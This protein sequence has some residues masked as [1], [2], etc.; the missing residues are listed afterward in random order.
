MKATSSR[1]AVSILASFA[2]AL[3]PLAVRAEVLS[4]PGQ[5]PPVIITEVQT[6]LGSG[7]ASKEF[8][9]LYNT[10]QEDI[11]LIGWQLWY[12]SATENAKLDTPGKVISLGTP[13]VPVIIPANGYLVIAH[14]SYA[15]AITADITYNFAMADNGTL[16]LLSLFDAAACQLYSEDMVGWGSAKFYEGAAVVLPSGKQVVA[17]YPAEGGGYVDT[18]VNADDFVALAASA[19]ATEATPGEPNILPAKQSAGVAEPPEH[20][21]IVIDP[22]CQ[23]I[24][25]TEPEEEP[26]TPVDPAEP[27]YIEE[28]PE[29][30]EPEPSTP[31][32]T[33]PVGNA[34]LRPPSLSEILPN[35]A[36]PQTDKDDEFIEVYN[37]NEVYFDLSGYIL[38][39]GLTTKRRY[40]IPAGTKLPPKAF[41]AFF[42]AE[43]KLALSNS[44]SQVALLDP[45]GRVLVISEPYGAAK[46]GQAWVFANGIWQWTTK[47]TPNALNVVSAPAVKSKSTAKK[48]S[49]VSTASA[50]KS[51]T[52]SQSGDVRSMEDIEEATVVAASSTPLHPGALALIA[53][54]AVLYGAY[55]YRRDVA[56]RIHQFRANRAAR[57]ALR[58]SVKGG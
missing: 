12:I 27:P 10:T 40:T 17:R 6:G 8:I 49:S 56:N 44:G 3:A 5:L 14:E 37:P 33:I 36:S 25:P 2:V 41:L 35:P 18:D 13:E 20:A 39:V 30:S 53:A 48:S 29:V 34:G 28:P 45:L 38:E 55:E 23:L 43:T 26:S 24:E 47:P 21:G 15:T 4:E 9:E 57:R 54:S 46:D 11:E 7:N 1:I 42:S 31:Q 52:G 19:T 22:N 16:R 51:G 32:P 50:T 58:Q